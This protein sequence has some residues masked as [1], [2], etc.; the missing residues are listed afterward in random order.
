MTIGV[1]A[2]G[3]RGSVTAELAVGLPAVVVVLAACLGALGL[4]ADQVRAHDAAADAARLLGRGESTA[5]AE[6]HVQIIVPGARL[7]VRF[8]DDLVCTTV[9]VERPVL[10]VPLRVEGS[11][12]AL[13]GGR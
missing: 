4:A 3:D 9:S 12:C 1:L 10:A 8:V 2:G 5:A 13:G 6:R 11:S 7:V